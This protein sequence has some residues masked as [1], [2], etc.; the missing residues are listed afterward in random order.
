VKQRKLA[1]VGGRVFT[2]SHDAWAEAVGVVGRRIGAV[3]TAKRVLREL[4]DAEVVDIDGRVMLPGFI[5]AHNHFLATGESLAMLDVRYPGV[6]TAKGLVAAIA[7]VAT[8][9][10]PGRWITAY[11][12]DHARYPDGAP[13]R[14]DL[15]RVAPDHPVLV[16]HVSGHHALLNTRA[17]ALRGIDDSTPDPPG[18]SFVRDQGGRNTGLC[19]DAATGLASPVVVDIGHHGPNF[20]VQAPLPDLVDAVERAGHAFLAAGLTTVCDAQ[21]TSRELEAYREAR[22]VARLPVRVVCMP[23]SHQLGEYASLGLAGPFGD[24]RLRVGPMKFY[25]DGSLIGGTAVFHEPYDGQEGSLYWEPDELRI[26]VARA[27]SLGWQVGI[28][29]QGDRA[30]GIA[31]DAIEAGIREAPRPDPRHRIE[32]AGFPTPELI[33]RMA[34]LGVITVN[35][36]SYLYESGD[37]FLVRLPDRAQGLQPLRD[38]I[39]AGVRV[40]VSSDSDVA[41]Y[42]PLDTI[43]AAVE[44]R[45]REGE[46]I[47]ADHALTVEEAARAHTIEAAVSIFAEDRLGSIE[48]G[49]LA[50]L[51]ILD[52]DP[53]AVE[54]HEIREIPAWMTVLDGK[55]VFRAE[56]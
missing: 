27:H 21:V 23:L 24:D 14:F 52:A 6:T 54:P 12:F 46:P 10:P 40:V 28:H 36:P 2:S 16:H 19:L 25:C 49:K 34:D 11:G 37:D 30:I 44:R 20:H 50:D 8:T 53:F 42:R 41:S 5:D 31:L 35:Q 29:A 39:R 56:S 18:G 47:G 15:D 38:E 26:A 32:H 3:G 51:V 4:P 7:H 43:S 55:I 9:T 33:E 17:L 45:T 13:T 22:R 48:E 1:F